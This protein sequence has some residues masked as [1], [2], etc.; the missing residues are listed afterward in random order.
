MRPRPGEIMFFHSGVNEF[1]FLAD[2]RLSGGADKLYE[3]AFCYGEVDLRHYW[4]EGLHGS[5]IGAV[6]ENLDAFASACLQTL[7]FGAT[8]LVLSLD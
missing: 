2:D 6:D 8:T 5:L 7:E 4:E 3:L 1:A